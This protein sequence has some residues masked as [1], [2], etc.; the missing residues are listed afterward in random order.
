MHPEIQKK[1]EEL[2]AALCQYGSP[3]TVAVRLFM[4]AG[5]TEVEIQ[6]RSPEQLKRSGYSMQNLKGDFIK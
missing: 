5:E 6:T 1:I 2:R 4:S 3:E